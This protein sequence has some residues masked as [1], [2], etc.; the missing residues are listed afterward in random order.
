MP[1]SDT[2]NI[3]FDQRSCSIDEFCAFELHGS[4]ASYYKLRRKKLGPEELIIPETNIVRITPQAR[5]AWRERM[6][7]LG[8]TKDAKRKQAKRHRQRVAAAK[9]AAASLKHV[10][11]KRAHKL[12]RA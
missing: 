3:P 1:A 6:K 11:N 12:A 10:S 8:K 9:K 2:S 5:A 7:K 4:R